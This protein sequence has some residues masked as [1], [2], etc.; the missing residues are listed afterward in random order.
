MKVVR[1]ICAAGPV[2]DVTIKS[3][4][5]SH[6]KRRPK[7]RITSEAVQKN[8]ER[9]AVKKLA[10]IINANFGKGCWHITL[11]YAEEVSHLR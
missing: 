10:R 5:A 6:G 1:E 4:T 2:I 7:K 9:L 3:G 11:T 8:N